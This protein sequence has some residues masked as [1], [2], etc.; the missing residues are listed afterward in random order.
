[1][2][3]TGGYAP[4][5]ATVVREKRAKHF[6]DNRWYHGHTFSNHPLGGI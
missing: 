5:G 3:I 6:D 4:L 2:G 1:V